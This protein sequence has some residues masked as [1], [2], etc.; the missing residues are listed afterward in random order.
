MERR[1]SRRSRRVSDS[2]RPTLRTSDADVR[3]S[4]ANSLQP[5][6][7]WCAS[8]LIVPHTSAAR[9]RAAAGFVKMSTTASAV[10]R[11]ASAE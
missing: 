6:Q 9:A 2:A 10:H 8:C 5:N 11:A 1:S 4:A 3:I 7:K